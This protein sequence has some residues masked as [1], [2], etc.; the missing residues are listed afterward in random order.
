[1]TSPSTT[2]APARP[3]SPAAAEAQALRKMTVEIRGQQWGAS[4]SPEVQWAV[5][6]YCLR[7]NLDAVRHVEVL[8][9]RIYLTA[10]FYREMG[11]ELLLDGTVIPDEPQLIHADARLDLLA[12][13]EGE[14]AKWAREESER[15]VRAR[16]QFGVDEES[17]AAAV[18]RFRLKSGAVIYG[19]NWIGGP[20]AK[21][22]D[23]VG[24][25]EPTKTAITRA[26]RRAWRQVVD[27]VPQFRDKVQH[28]EVSAKLATAE[29]AQIVDAEPKAPSHPAAL[30]AGGYQEPTPTPAGFE[31]I[32]EETRL[33]A[34]AAEAQSERDA[35]QVALEMELDRQ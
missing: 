27:A 26:E 15:R 22:R 6:R 4:C 11:S 24:Q 33:K 16:I 9:G 21:K 2:V 18:V 28:I 29:V 20:Q 31:P 7:N 8:G 35:E 32:D 34:I 19:V 13:G 25:A 17:P 3:L 14:Q 5:A 1:M 12:K 30:G 10:E 23:P